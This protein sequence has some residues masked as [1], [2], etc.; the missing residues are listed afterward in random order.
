MNNTS[1][2]SEKL[3]RLSLTVHY[4]VW[5]EGKIKKKKYAFA[6]NS[7]RKTHLKIGKNVNSFQESEIE[8]FALCLNLLFINVMIFSS[9]NDFVRLSKNDF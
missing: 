1:C 4:V 6:D 5:S 8:I 7:T 2:K 9:Y 3:S